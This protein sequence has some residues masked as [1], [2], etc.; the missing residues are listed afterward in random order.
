M[1]RLI[2][3]LRAANVGGHGKIAMAGLCAFAAGLGFANPRSVL[4]SGNLVFES[5]SKPDVAE[6][7]LEAEAAVRLDLRTDFFV[8]TPGEWREMIAGNPFPHE[9]RRDPSRL[10]AVVLK[11][12][13]ASA[14]VTALQAAIVG[15]ERVAAGGRHLYITYP[16]GQ[17]R[18][19]LT[20]A[21]IEKTLGTR[22][23]ARNWNTVLKL[24]AL[25]CG[26]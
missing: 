22:G 14:A 12:A 9:A 8:R 4:Q 10:V 17:G 13:P 18:S 19:K 23:T 25:A 6:R 1:P 7:R 15:R 21:L 24:D 16:D 20:G 3:L 5:A 11:R 2:A 26:R